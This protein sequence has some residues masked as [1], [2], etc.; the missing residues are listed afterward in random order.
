METLSTSPE[1]G[2]AIKLLDADTPREVWVEARQN[3]IGASDIPVLAQLTPP[4]WG[5]AFDMYWKKRLGQSQDQNPGM[6]W[7]HIHE[8]Q[9]MDHFRFEHPNL[10]VVS[11]LNMILGH[12]AHKWATCT[13]DGLIYTQG[14][15]ELFSL[16][17]VKTAANGKYWGP[18]GSDEVPD[19]YHAQCQWQMMVTGVPSMWLAVLIAGNDYREYI[20]TADLEYQ[21][22]LLNVGQEFRTLLLNGTPP[23]IDGLTATTNRLRELYSETVDKTVDLDAELVDDY[24]RAQDAVRIAKAQLSR[25]QNRIRDSL[26]DATRGQFLGVDIV[27]RLS[28][29]RT[30]VDGAELMAKYP[31]IWA[32]VARQTTVDVLK[33]LA[34]KK[35]ARAWRC[36]T[37]TARRSGRT[38][39][40]VVRISTRS[41]A[42]PKRFSAPPRPSRR[43]RTL[44]RHR[45]W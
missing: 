29:T 16:L 22:G 17:E 35:W 25:A 30:N 5:S 15:S 13:P 10:N 23:P 21:A 41:S 19:H 20:L 6:Y 39:R 26:K 34:P 11:G 18:S 1:Y 40:E 44:T 31:Q 33:P 32:E 28:Y 27:Q 45:G 36:S 3:L 38:S 9:I 43:S 24:H 4:A 2:R 14:S 12:A 42:A 37:T 7:G 8:P